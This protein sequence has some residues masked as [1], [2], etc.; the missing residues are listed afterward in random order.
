MKNLLI[1][2]AK[3]YVESTIDIFHEKKIKRLKSLTLTQILKRKNPYLFRAKNILTPHDFIKGVLDAHISSNEE[4]IFGGWLEEFAIFICAK[5]Y[6][7]R[8]STTKGIDL[9]FDSENIRYIVSIKSG[10]NWGNS[11]QIADMKKNFQTAI[12]TLRTNHKKL[13]I[14][15]VNGCCYGKDSK[16]CKEGYHKY[17][18]QDFWEFISGNP[19]LYT[20]II[21]PL[22]YKAK[23]KNERY[24]EEY[25][26]VLTGLEYQFIQ[27]FCHRDKS[28]NWEKIV[29]F[30]SGKNMERA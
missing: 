26:K 1:N 25:A 29:I 12:K 18:G 28:I 21:E 19:S 30:N 23:E 6:N 24:L 22:G 9:E 17:C 8:K 4:T 15:A 14:I 16:P 2:D 10:P 5:V 13:N 3:K 20:E 7:G 27:D 11:G